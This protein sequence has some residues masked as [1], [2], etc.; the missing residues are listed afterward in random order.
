MNISLLCSYVKDKHDVKSN[1]ND[2]A[3]LIIQTDDKYWFLDCLEHAQKDDPSEIY[4]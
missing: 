3:N 1:A 4:R 2:A